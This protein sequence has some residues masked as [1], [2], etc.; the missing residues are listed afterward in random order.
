MAA[1]R[2][3]IALAGAHVTAD[4]ALKVVV[5]SYAVLLPKIG[6]TRPANLGTLAKGDCTL[7]DWQI[8]QRSADHLV[9]YLPY[10]YEIY[11]PDAGNLPDTVTAI[12]NTLL[13]LIH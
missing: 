10:Y 13:N 9:T 12:H 5:V 8:L 4:S 2:A 11:P 7:E 3:L 6:T 1:K